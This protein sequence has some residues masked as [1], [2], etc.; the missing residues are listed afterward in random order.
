M[1][2]RLFALSALAATALA[3]TDIS[4]CTSTNSVVTVS[5]RNDVTTYS[6]VLWY[7]PDTGEICEVLDCGGGRAPPKTDVPGCG[8]YKG[9]ETYSP[10]FMPSST[11]DAVG[12][13]ETGA[14]GEEA[15]QT[16]PTETG[17]GDKPEASGEAGEGE[18]DGDEDEDSGAA[19]MGVSLGGLVAVAAWGLF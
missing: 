18:G 1:A 12:E 16:V 17:T 15:T 10:R 19:A 6:T 7:I 4:G 13:K 2:L 5:G 14:D 3:K 8:A 11:A 9:T